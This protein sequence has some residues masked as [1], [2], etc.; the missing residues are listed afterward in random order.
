MILKKYVHHLLGGIKENVWIHSNERTF[1]QRKLSGVILS[2]GCL[3]DLPGYQT[4]A[5]EY[6]KLLL[7][8]K[9]KTSPDIRHTVYYYG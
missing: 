7:N 5:Y 9:V 3:F 1:L 6:F 2:L 8:N 4:K